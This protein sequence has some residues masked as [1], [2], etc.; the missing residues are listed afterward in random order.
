MKKIAILVLSLLLA[1]TLAG[2][3]PN[4]QGSGNQ[5][6]T[7]VQEESAGNEDATATDE[8]NPCA[9]DCSAH[10]GAVESC[11]CHGTCGTEGCQCHGSH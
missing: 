6:S 1:F 3:D 11:H 7:Q 4:D 10:T 8:E 9:T 5:P 2:C